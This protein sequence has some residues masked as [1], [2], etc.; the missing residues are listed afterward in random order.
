MSGLAVEVVDEGRLIGSIRLGLH[1][2]RNAEFGYSLGSAYWRKGY[3]YEA[4][5]ALV[6]VAFDTLGDAAGLGDVRRPA[7]RL[8]RD[9]GEAGDAPRRRLAPEPAGAGRRVAGHH[10][11]AMLAQEWAARRT[12]A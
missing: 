2:H 1:D 3:G 8:V 6:S 7:T 9:H 5:H 11:Y 4:A 10:L 12:V